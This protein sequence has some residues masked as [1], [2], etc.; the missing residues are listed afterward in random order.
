M[1]TTIGALKIIGYNMH[2]RLY[3]SSKRS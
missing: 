3:C 1:G 2:S